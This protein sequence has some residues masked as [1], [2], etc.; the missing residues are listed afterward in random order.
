MFGSDLHEILA[1][2]LA[3]QRR[4][5]A[6]K[7]LVVL[8]NRRLRE[9]LDQRIRRARMEGLWTG[10]TRAQCA[11]LHNQEK[12]RV[13]KRLLELE[14]ECVLGRGRLTGIKR[15]KARARRRRASQLEVS[16]RRK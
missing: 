8:R 4:Q 11:I 14:H 16:R 6:L 5:R 12:A 3:M 10:L 15:A 7:S 2:E 13:R 1:E 9:S